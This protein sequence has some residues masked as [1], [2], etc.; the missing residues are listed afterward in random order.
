[1]V[2][3]ESDLEEERWPDTPPGRL[4][5]M[6]DAFEVGQA[7]Y[8]V[9]KLGVP[10]RL[11]AGPR[12]A[13][14]VAAEVGARPGPL[15]RVLRLLAAVGLFSQDPEDRFGLTSL[16]ELLVAGREGSLAP[17]AVFLGEELY[18][19]AG[20][21]LYTVRTGET[22]F[23]HVFGTGW[24]DYLG[25]HPEANASFQAAMVAR[26]TN[27]G[28]LTEAYDFSAHRT[29]VDVGGGHGAVLAAL[30]RATPGLR[31]I[32]FDLP[33]VIAG[34]SDH[35][36]AQGVADRVRL[37]AGSLL[38]SVPAGEELYLE[39]G[40]LHLF[41][42]REVARALENLRRAVPAGGTLLLAELVVPPGSTPSPAKQ[43]DVRMLYASGGRER[44][45]PEWRALLGSAGFDLVRVEPTPL[46]PRLLVARPRAAGPDRPSAG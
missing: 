7:I 17:R 16:G 6:L 34:A 30:L 26:E 31:G 40:V 36:R 20:D 10:D 45:E 9:A 24:L 13:E 38:E 28:A 35:L 46:A 14:E 15:Y 27:W 29:L 4:R 3:P 11:V 39:V 43:L 37:E 32:L 19:A 21:L 8:V 12:R 25:S 2:E 42:D 18:R 1:M 22:A 33:H 23:P 41:P 5:A 44:T